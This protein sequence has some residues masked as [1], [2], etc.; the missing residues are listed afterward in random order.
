MKR[1]KEEIKGNRYKG[2]NQINEWQNIKEK[3]ERE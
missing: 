3:S 1:G 2:E